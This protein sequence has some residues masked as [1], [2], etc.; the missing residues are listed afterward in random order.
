M[1]FQFFLVNP[2]LLLSKYKNDF[3][4]REINENENGKIN[5]TRLY[6]ENNRNDDIKSRSNKQNTS[7][8]KKYSEIKSKIINT[9]IKN[10]HKNENQNS[11]N[12]VDKQQIK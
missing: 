12:A 2:D 9:S 8:K 11:N 3:K 5:I 10:K 4:S 1:Y 7:G 6:Q